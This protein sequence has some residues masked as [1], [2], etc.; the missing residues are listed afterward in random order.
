[1]ESV[2]NSAF[3]GTHIDKFEEK[4]FQLY[5]KKML[6]SLYSFTLWFC[7][8]GVDTAHTCVEMLGRRGARARIFF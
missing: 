7:L 5:F 3:L 1:L 8:G 6:Y 4:S 2:L